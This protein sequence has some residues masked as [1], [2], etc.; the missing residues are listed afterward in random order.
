MNDNRNKKNRGQFY[1]IT[2]PFHNQLFLKWLNSIDN[3]KQETIIEPFAGANN[4]V[5]MLHDLSYKNKWECYD[6]EPNIQ[7]NFNK[8]IVQQRDTINNFPKGYR[9]AIT[10][11]PYLAKNSAKRSGLDFPDTHFD[12]LYKLALHRCLEN[13]DYVA[14]IIPDSFITCRLFHER[15]FGVVSLSCKM[16]DDTDVPV[17]LA[18]FI[19][20]SKKN[21]SRDFKYY[22]GNTDLGLYS[23]MIKEKEKTL[24]K[25]S[26]HHWTFNNPAGEVGLYAIDDSR[27]QSIRFVNGN[28]IPKKKIKSTSR[29]ITKISGIPKEID[30]NEFINTA[31]SILDEFRN[32]TNDVFLT[33]FRGLRKDGDYRKR[34]DFE[35]AKRILDASIKKLE[36]S[37][38]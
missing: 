31:N 28:Q 34:L 29:G 33:S 24:A 35:T 18:L 20:E 7:S 22:K 19:P 12:D 9:V 30:L 26:T 17:C 2:N 21:G 1:T 11:P 15:L 8:Y 36:E 27:S 10:N 38:A 14:A 32:T 23:E 6:I 16:F 4:I 25:Q 5:A 37:N 3:I 13:V